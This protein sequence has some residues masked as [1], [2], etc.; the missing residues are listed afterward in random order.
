MSRE[1]PC[2]SHHVDAYGHL[3]P[4]SSVGSTH[5]QAPP[6]NAAYPS[7]GP[8]GGCQAHSQ[9]PLLQ[10][11]AASAC[12]PLGVFSK[13]HTRRYKSRC[14]SRSKKTEQESRGVTM[15]HKISARQKRLIISWSKSSR[16]SSDL[17]IMCGHKQVHFHCIPPSFP[18]GA[19]QREAEHKHGDKAWRTQWA[20]THRQ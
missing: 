4:D 5:C 18:E 10:Q 20:W 2:L 19:V 1:E 6:R 17:S 16:E 12:G 8:W 7:T 14:A 15:D 9:P 3:C 11:A 13:K